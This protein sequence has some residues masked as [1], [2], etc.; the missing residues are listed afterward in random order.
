MCVYSWHIIIH[1]SR[2]FG[3]RAFYCF[4]NGGEIEYEKA[5]K[6]RRHTN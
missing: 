1:D 6:E 5:W 2:K 4:R 3:K